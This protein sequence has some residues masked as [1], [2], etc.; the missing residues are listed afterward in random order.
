MSGSAE[1]AHLEGQATKSIINI[2][3]L[4]LHLCCKEFRGFLKRSSKSCL[5]HSKKIPK[6]VLKAF[7][8]LLRRLHMP[9]NISLIL[10]IEEQVLHEYIQ[11]DLIPGIDKKVLR[12]YPQR[13]LLS[14]VRPIH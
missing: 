4:P 2:C 14:L 5:K 10:A 1:T 12:K 13:N 9:I 8:P 11:P 3:M 7:K 6:S